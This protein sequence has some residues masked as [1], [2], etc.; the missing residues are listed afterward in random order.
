MLEVAD[1]ALAPE[2][3]KIAPSETYRGSSLPLIDPL[4]DQ[5]GSWTMFSHRFESVVYEPRDDGLSQIELC[6]SYPSSSMIPTKA[7]RDG[8]VKYFGTGFQ[9]TMH[10]GEGLAPGTVE[11]PKIMQRCSDC[12]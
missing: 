5:T 9:E 1:H 3:C 4:V 11:P 8:K 2:L 6:F 7:I 10:V 12:K